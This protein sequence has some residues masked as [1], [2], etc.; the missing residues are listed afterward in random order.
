MLR[1]P[2]LINGTGQL[3]ASE[4]E[5]ATSTGQRTPFRC[6][7]E[8]RAKI[9]MGETEDLSR[10]DARARDYQS[11]KE[12]A[13]DKLNENENENEMRIAASNH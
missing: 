8:P 11:L 7:R 12:A 4:T 2:R 9:L 10:A 6:G 13:Y 3:A 1:R 5:I